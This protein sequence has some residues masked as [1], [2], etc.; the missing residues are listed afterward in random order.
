MV[1]A[2]SRPRVTGCCCSSRASSIP[3]VVRSRYRR[4]H[5]DHARWQCGSKR[6]IAL[7][8]TSRTALFL[9]GHRNRETPREP[10]DGRSPWQR[11]RAGRRA[12]AIGRPEET[13]SDW[14][15]GKSPFDPSLSSR[16]RITEVSTRSALSKTYGQMWLRC[17]V[18]RRYARLKLAGLH[19]VDYRTKTFSCSV[20]R[21]LLL[22]GRAHQ[23][24]RNARRPVRRSG[25]TGT[26]SGRR[27]APHG[28]AAALDVEPGRRTARS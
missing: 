28:A 9:D 4:F 18:C 14:A 8:C 12:R 11:G 3:C 22:P 26:P 15:N 10:S 1:G 25:E 24:I 2:S 20:F 6:S 13:I 16:S 7:G 21:G 17:D 23:G 27:Q 5:F 19:D